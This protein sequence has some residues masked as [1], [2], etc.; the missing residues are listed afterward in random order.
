M[1]TVKN[2]H[3]KTFIEGYFKEIINSVKILAANEDIIEVPFGDIAT[4]RRA[5]VIFK[6]LQNANPNIY[7]IYAG[8][9]NNL[10]LI[11]DYM[12]HLQTLRFSRVPAINLSWMHPN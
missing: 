2:N 10:L 1:P 3:L 7:Y 4:K 8:Y 11:N 6:E 5:L 9:T 12:N